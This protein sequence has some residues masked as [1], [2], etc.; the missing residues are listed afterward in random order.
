MSNKYNFYIYKN[1]QNVTYIKI[2]KKNHLNILVYT[3]CNF[4]KI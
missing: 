1:K 2:Q 3:H 4:K